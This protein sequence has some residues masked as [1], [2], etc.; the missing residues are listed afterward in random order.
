M[1]PLGAPRAHAADV[2][3]RR[4]SKLAAFSISTVA[5]ATLALA[6]CDQSSENN[7][8]AGGSSMPGTQQAAPAAAEHMA[9]AG[10]PE[11]ALYVDGELAGWIAVNRL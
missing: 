7:Q 1:K 10:A 5:F 8:A 6:G 9:E 4:L 11:G 3:R 2:T